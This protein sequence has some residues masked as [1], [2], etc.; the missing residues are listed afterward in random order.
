LGFVRPAHCPLS[1]S[2]GRLS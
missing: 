1:R 2:Q